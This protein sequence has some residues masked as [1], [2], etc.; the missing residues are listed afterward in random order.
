MSHPKRQHRSRRPRADPPALESARVR[1]GARC[2]RADL[3][4]L[5]EA[6]RWAPSSG[7]EQPWRFLVVRSR[8]AARALARA[9]GVAHRQESGL[10]RGGA[11][12]G[13]GR[14]AADARAQRDR[15]IR[16]AWYDAGQA[17]A[18]LT[19]SG[20]VAGARDSADGRLRSRRRARRRVGVPAEF[21]PAVVMAIGYA[22]DPGA[23]SIEKHRAAERSPA[24]P[25]GRSETSC[26]T[27]RWGQSI[28]S[29]SR[30]HLAS[31][32][33]APAGF[34][35]PESV[36]FM[37]ASISRASAAPGQWAGSTRRS[38]SRRPRAGR[39]SCARRFR[40]ASRPPQTP[41]QSFGRHRQK[42]L[43]RLQR[44]RIGASVIEDAEDARQRRRAARRVPPESARPGDC[45]DGRRPASGRTRR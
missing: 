41:R 5:F 18:L 31:E 38:A 1:C 20:D 39:G 27:G 32:P 10:G 6:A 42:L 9:A 3:L 16:M 35:P 17:V 23:L 25:Q 13:A 43:Q 37:S 40:P 22:G 2:P 7:N 33:S 44:L 4:R 14:R 12:A 15:R 24:Q 29:E 34:E 45:R 8:R 21:E 11:R 19:H 26:S 30:G 28:Q 36:R